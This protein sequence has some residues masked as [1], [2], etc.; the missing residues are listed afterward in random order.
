MIYEL[1]HMFLQEDAEHKSIFG[2][3]SD[4]WALVVCLEPHFLVYPKKWWLLQHHL[5][6]GREH[7]WLFDFS[8]CIIDTVTSDFKKDLQQDW[9]RVLM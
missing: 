8:L 5:P 4:L 6:S 9:E 1:Y 3:N 2:G 7:L